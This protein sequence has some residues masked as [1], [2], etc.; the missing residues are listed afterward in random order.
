MMFWRGH[1]RDARPG[2]AQFRF[3]QVRV[4][5]KMGNKTS[6]VDA[7]LDGSKFASEYFLPSADCDYRVCDF[8]KDNGCGGDDGFAEVLDATQQPS[9]VEEG[10]YLVTDLL[11]DRPRVSHTC[12]FAESSFLFFFTQTHSASLFCVP[13]KRFANFFLR[14]ARISTCARTNIVAITMHQYAILL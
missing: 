7:N 4:R 6:S 11:F 9:V 3:F 14:S 2:Q 1:K 13:F 8:L 10:P 5:V 12:L